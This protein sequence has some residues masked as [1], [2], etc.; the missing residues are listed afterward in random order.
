MDWFV[1]DGVVFPG[2]RNWVVSLNGSHAPSGS[3]AAERGR[4]DAKIQD[5]V[6]QR[7]RD[8]PTIQ[9]VREVLNA[10][11]TGHRS[12]AVAPPVLS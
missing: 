2:E 10:D 9:D 5:S 11:S 7:F 3:N 4:A 8:A 6:L 1:D 12:A